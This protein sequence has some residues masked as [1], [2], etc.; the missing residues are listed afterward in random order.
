MWIFVVI[1][2]SDTAL[3]E[4]DETSGLP[5]FLSDI[6]Q[7]DEV[8]ISFHRAYSKTDNYG[9][10]FCIELNVKV[11]AKNKII[12]PSRYVYGIYVLDNFGNDLDVTDMVPRYCD[13]LMPGEEKLFIITFNIRPLKNTKYLLLKIPNGIFGNK[14]PFEL[15]IFNTGS[16]GPIT[17]EERDQLETGAGAKYWQEGKAYIDFMPDDIQL[18]RIDKILYAAIFVGL[19]AFCSLVLILVWCLKAAKETILC[20]QSFLSFFARWLN[21][22]HS[23]LLMVYMF[24]ALIS[25]FW[26]I[27]GVIIV[28]AGG[29]ITTE[30]VSAIVFFLSSWVLL[31]FLSFLALYETLNKWRAIDH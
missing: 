21:E 12:K 25:L 3:A 9:S 1:G 29:M 13:S 6:Y 30:S 17:K 10:K 11:L 15:M 27:F 16:K 19:C 24:S 28:I 22:R 20:N 26:L 5:Q 7:E 31:S 4:P 8:S 14:N 23:H 18:K 2:G